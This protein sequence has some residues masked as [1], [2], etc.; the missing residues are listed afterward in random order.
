MEVE[1]LI[2]SV[3]SALD[4]GGAVLQLARP[5]TAPIQIK[6][7]N[8]VSSFIRARPKNEWQ[9]SSIYVSGM[10]VFIMIVSAL[11]YRGT[12][13]LAVVLLFLGCP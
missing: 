1:V 2:G 8:K 6:V 3:L 12:G 11:I 9:Y 7:G 13:N 5:T 10:T 4:S